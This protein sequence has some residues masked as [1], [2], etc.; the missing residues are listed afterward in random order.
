MSVRLD[1]PLTLRQLFQGV[2]AFLHAPIDRASMRK[3]LAEGYFQGFPPQA[4]NPPPQRFELLGDHVFVEGFDRRKPGE[5]GV[6][7]GS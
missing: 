1:G 7:C 3:L 4:L 6:V 2:K 5:Y